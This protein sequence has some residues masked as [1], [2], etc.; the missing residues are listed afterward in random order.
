MAYRGG[1]PYMH[2]F[3]DDDILRQRVE[4][5]DMKRLE[6]KVRRYIMGPLDL[7]YTDP[8]QRIWQSGEG[9]DRTPYAGMMERRFAKRVRYIRSAVSNTV[10]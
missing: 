1:L 9:L 7:V 3:R 4:Q 8:P 5:L 10:R 2:G 6:I